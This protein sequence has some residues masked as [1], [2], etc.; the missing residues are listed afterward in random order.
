MID[1][2]ECQV[3]HYARSVLD[4]K[5]ELRSGRVWAE[6]NLNGDAQKNP[7][8]SGLF[9]KLVVETR[10]WF[11]TNCL[12]STPAGF[13]IGPAAAKLEKSGK[14]LRAEGHKGVALRAFRRV[15]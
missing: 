11:N 12:R 9:R 15:P 7:V 5:G 3:L 13:F 14:V 1:E 10:D 2:L 4:E 6:L 8:L